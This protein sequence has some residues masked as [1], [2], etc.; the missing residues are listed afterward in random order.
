MKCLILNQPNINLNANS[1]VNSLTNSINSDINAS[2]IKPIQTTILMPIPIDSQDNQEMN[3]VEYFQPPNMN[4]IG[5]EE[6]NNFDKTQILSNKNINNAVAPLQMN[7]MKPIQM[8]NMKQE[9]N[10]MV[11]EMNNRMPE[12]KNMMPG[13]NNMMPEMN[14]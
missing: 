12:M 9:V 1:V 3:P 2:E 13:I 8:N 14:N 5:I 11:P 7:N 4:D 6:M 10:N